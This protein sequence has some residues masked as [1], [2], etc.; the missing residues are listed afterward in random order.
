MASPSDGDPGV[1]RGHSY[2]S[3]YDLLL[4]SLVTGTRQK[5]TILDIAMLQMERRA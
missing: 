2:L 4:Y 1:G 3:V 5:G